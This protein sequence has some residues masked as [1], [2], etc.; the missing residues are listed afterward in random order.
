MGRSATAEELG[1]TAKR[2]AKL[3]EFLM[4]GVRDPDE[5]NSALQRI[6]EGDFAAPMAGFNM[7]NEAANLIL[8]GNGACDIYLFGSIARHGVGNDIDLVVTL[9]PP[10]ENI[11]DHFYTYVGDYSISFPTT[12]SERRTDALSRLSRGNL[13]SAQRLE[14][15]PLD[16]WLLPED[17]QAKTAEYQRRWLPA[18]D[19]TFLETVKR[20]ARKFDQAL[21]EFPRSDPR[22]DEAAKLLRM[23]SS[24]VQGNLVLLDLVS[25]VGQVLQ[26]TL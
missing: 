17:W 16:I 5:V 11:L 26:I 6:I 10:W 15:M 24:D 13:V 4:T 8:E 7:A 9:P 19:Q 21:G 20:Q 25:R 12:K 23:I 14:E 18:S 2:I 22:F 1:S 3:L